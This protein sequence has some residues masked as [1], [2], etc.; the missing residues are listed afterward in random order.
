MKRTKTILALLTL[1]AI[2]IGCT[3]TKVTETAP[4]SGQYTTNVVV[5]PKLETALTTA[6]SINA[7][8]APVNPFSGL[9]DIGLGAIALGA[10]WFAK[11]KNDQLN[12]KTVLLKTVV[13]SVDAIDQKNVK[14]A[15]QAHAVKVGVEGELSQ[16]VKQVGSGMQ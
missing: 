6:G 16:F 1:S 7:A 10:S 15:I 9:I 5:D 8:T 2:L 11:R 12:S 13:Q 4:G 3:A 14:D